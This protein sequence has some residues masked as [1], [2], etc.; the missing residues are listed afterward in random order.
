MTH[1]ESLWVILYESLYN[2]SL[3]VVE[4]FIQVDFHF[5]EHMLMLD[6][7]S[8]LKKHRLDSLGHELNENQ[9]QNVW[10]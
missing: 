3:E 9:H 8:L 5:F 6:Q 7:K 1:N 2:F 4:R 10:D